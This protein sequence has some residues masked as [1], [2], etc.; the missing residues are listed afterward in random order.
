M[1]YRS[2]DTVKLEKASQYV[3]RTTND[4]LAFYFS[5]VLPKPI[6]ANNV[7]L[8]VHTASIMLSESSPGGG[9]ISD[10]NGS[11]NYINKQAGVVSFSVPLTSQASKALI[12]GVI[13]FNNATVTFS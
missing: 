8:R 13:N 11:I 2:G 5:I 7:A 9:D 3:G 12:L 10:V 6:I 1:A 4:K